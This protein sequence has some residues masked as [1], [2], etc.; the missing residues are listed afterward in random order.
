[1]VERVEDGYPFFVFLDEAA[2]LQQLKVMRSIRLF[3]TREAEEVD[4]LGVNLED[5][6]LGE[7]E[8]E[9]EDEDVD[10][11][12]DEEDDEEE[13]EEEEEED[14]DLDDWPDTEWDAG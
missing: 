3:L 2:T 8:D 6:D 1:M 13:E 9:D 10:E 12:E 11:D 5:F 7:V 4:L 14:M